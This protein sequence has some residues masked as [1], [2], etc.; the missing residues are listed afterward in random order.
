MHAHFAH[1]V[2]PL[3]RLALCASRAL[4]TRVPH[5]RLTLFASRALHTRV[6]HMRL[7]LFASRALHVRLTCASRAPRP[8]AGASA[9]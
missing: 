1:Y 5:M 7:T 3:V 2:D 8:F 6:P 4:H 9:P